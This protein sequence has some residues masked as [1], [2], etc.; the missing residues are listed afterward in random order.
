MS[1]IDLDQAKRI[2]LSG[3]RKKRREFH[4]RFRE[5]YRDCVEC[6]EF[7]ECE[8]ATEI[9]VKCY[10]KSKVCRSEVDLKK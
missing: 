2:I 9:L 6:P 1:K 10:N 8:I 7:V 5:M 4:S 3:L